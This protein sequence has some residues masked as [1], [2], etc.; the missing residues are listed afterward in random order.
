MIRELIT[1]HRRHGTWFPDRAVRD[2]VNLGALDGTV[3]VGLLLLRRHDAS[4]A[5]LATLR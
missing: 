2:A 4:A 1:R 3:A 5:P